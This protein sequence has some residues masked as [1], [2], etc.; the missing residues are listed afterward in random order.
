M[1][2]VTADLV[3][4]AIQL[5]LA[6][7]VMISSAIAVLVGSMLVV[8]AAVLTDQAW[9]AVLVLVLLVTGALVLLWGVVLITQEIRRSRRSIVYESQAALGL[10]VQQSAGG[11]EEVHIESSTP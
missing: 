10:V 2:R 1:V 9:L 3:A 6:P 8:A 4:R 5:I 11:P 7:A